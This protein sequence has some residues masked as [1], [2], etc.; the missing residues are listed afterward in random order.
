M[1]DEHK[2]DGADSMLQEEFQEPALWASVEHHDTSSF[3]QDCT[4][5]VPD[6]ENGH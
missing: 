5:T 1:G 2:I 4:A 6:V 3:H